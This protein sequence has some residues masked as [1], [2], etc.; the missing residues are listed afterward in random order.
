MAQVVR[1]YLN[2]DAIIGI[3]LIP[4]LMEAGKV[5]HK[6]VSAKGGTLSFFD[7]VKAIEQL[8]QEYL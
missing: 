7:C 1:K 2:D 5:M 3:L 6:K 4:S 8:R